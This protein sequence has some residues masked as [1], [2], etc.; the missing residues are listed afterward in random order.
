MVLVPHLT[1]RYIQ[2][3]YPCVCTL[4][5]VQLPTSYVH[6]SVENDVTSVNFA[7]YWRVLACRFSR[8][9][10]RPTVR[11]ASPASEADTSGR[12]RHAC[13]MAPPLAI[14]VERTVRNGQLKLVFS[15]FF[16]FAAHKSGVW[17]LK[18]A[19]LKA[20]CLTVL[21]F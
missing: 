18:L 5:R 4:Y 15:F 6:T 8:F 16:S 19:C 11:S 10:P 17:L 9:A 2:C 7:S 1:C 14:G 20:V 21:T 13:A 12:V 3:S